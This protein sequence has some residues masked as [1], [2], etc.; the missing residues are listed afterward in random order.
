[1]TE[2]GSGD[3]GRTRCLQGWLTV[4]GLKGMGDHYRRYFEGLL[5]REPCPCPSSPSAAG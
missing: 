4:I 2:A 3:P 1:M 5:P